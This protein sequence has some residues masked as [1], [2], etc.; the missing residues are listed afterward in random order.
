MDP[1]CVHC[2]AMRIANKEMSDR[3]WEAR[4]RVAA[5]EAA[6]KDVDRLLAAYEERILSP[7]ERLMARGQ[8]I[9]AMREK[10]SRAAPP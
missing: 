8:L 5:L 3:M 2:A 1:P 9:G 7:A 4:D 6:L 10:I